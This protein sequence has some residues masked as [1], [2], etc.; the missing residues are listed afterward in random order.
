LGHIGTYWDILACRGFR[1]YYE[2]EHAADLS[3]VD[4]PNFASYATLPR[5]IEYDHGY[6]DS[7]AWLAA[8]LE[9]GR[10]TQE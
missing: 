3:R 2:A 1:L 4:S 10:L 6:A 5:G 8:T 9:H 7:C